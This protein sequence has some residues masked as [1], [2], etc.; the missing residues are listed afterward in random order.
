MVNPR[1]TLTTDSLLYQLM[2]LV[3]ELEVFTDLLPDGELRDSLHTLIAGFTERSEAIAQEVQ[4]LEYELT[5][6]T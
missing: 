6:E 5:R 2:A 1:D 3:V 4:L